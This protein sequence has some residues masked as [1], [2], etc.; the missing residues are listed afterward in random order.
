MNRDGANT[1]TAPPWG[2]RRRDRL[3]LL[4]LFTLAVVDLVV[5]LHLLLVDAAQLSESPPWAGALS[6]LPGH[7][8]RPL[9]DGLLIAAFALPFTFSRRMHVNVPG[10]VG[11]ALGGV[12]WGAL[13]GS[14]GYA[15]AQLHGLGMLSVAA[16]FGFC[17]LHL[18]ILFLERRW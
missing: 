12:S 13:A 18:G 3:P 8:P 15:A 17:V 4:L 10:W 7:S 11:L 6:L 9:G 2:R 5:G 16:A 1:R 14:F